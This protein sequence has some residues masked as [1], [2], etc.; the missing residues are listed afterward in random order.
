MIMMISKFD[1]N[2]TSLGLNDIFWG[3]NLG[4]LYF[5][6]VYWGLWGPPEM[7]VVRNHGG[8]TLVSVR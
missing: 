5:M 4:G 1:S 2:K 3:G 6:G 8:P 7:G